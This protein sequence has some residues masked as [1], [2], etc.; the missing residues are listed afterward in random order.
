MIVVLPTGAN[1]TQAT[2]GSTQVLNK[3]DT[4]RV[5]EQPGQPLL[6]HGG[7]GSVSALPEV[8]G[9]NSHPTRGPRPAYVN[10]LPS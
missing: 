7:M 4:M 5:A 8:Q 1:S 2:N 10:Y 9:H 6:G 3:G